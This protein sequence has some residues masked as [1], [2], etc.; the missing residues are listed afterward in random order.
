[1]LLL[2]RQQ[3]GGGWTSINNIIN[4]PRILYTSGKPIKADVPFI[5][6]EIT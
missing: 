3:S 6:T 4:I 1:M 2:C 5:I